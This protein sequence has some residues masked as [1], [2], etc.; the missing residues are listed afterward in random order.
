[1][2]AVKVRAIGDG[3]FQTDHQVYE[4]NLSRQARVPGRGLHFQPSRTEHILFDRDNLSGKIGNASP[5]LLEL[6]HEP[7]LVGSQGCLGFWG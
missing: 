6:L 5:T 3:L 1:M 7:T 2:Q 4:G